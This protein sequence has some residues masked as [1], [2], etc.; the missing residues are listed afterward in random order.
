VEAI[1][2]ARSPRP[3]RLAGQIDADNAL[4]LYRE[5]AGVVQSGNKTKPIAGAF[6]IQPIELSR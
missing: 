6:P 1:W 2:Q 4:G 3:W 5:C